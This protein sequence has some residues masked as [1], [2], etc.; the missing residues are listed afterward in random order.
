MVIQ[1]TLQGEEPE[2]RQQQNLGKWVEDNSDF[3][4]YLAEIN[5]YRKSTNTE[6]INMNDEDAANITG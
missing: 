4:T 6:D 2:F 1:R 5:K 3:D